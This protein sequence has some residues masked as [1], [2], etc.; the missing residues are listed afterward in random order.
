MIF[1]F[2]SFGIEYPYL[3]SEVTE[4]FSARSLQSQLT[5]NLACLFN[6]QQ[7]FLKQARIFSRCSL[8]LWEF[9]TRTRDERNEV[10]RMMKFIIRLTDSYRTQPIYETITCTFESKYLVWRGRNDFPDWNIIISFLN[11]ILQ[12]LKVTSSSYLLLQT[13]HLLKSVTAKYL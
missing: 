10:A 5:L 12:Y 7:S 4:Q 2:S 8:S 1:L 11:P 13:L 9:F 3:R 6:P